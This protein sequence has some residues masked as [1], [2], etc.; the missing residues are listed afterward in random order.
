MT[1]G[2]TLWRSLSRCARIE[3]ALARGSTADSRVDSSDGE[4]VERFC[5]SGSDSLAHWLLILQCH[6]T[7]G[8]HQICARVI[9]HRCDMLMVSA[10][11]RTVDLPAA[12]LMR[13]AAMIACACRLN[14][15]SR[16]SLA[17]S[18][19]AASSNTGRVAGSWSTPLLPPQL[20]I[21]LCFSACKSRYLHFMSMLTHHMQGPIAYR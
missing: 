10:D 20:L 12:K 5:T 8:I 1:L 3:S 15:R 2:F 19:A 16:P 21:H 6:P 17:A 9:A 14:L 4:R 18:F 7:G 11:E 13:R